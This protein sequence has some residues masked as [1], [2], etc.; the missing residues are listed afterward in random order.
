MSNPGATPPD[1]AR[2]DPDTPAVLL[3]RHEGWAEIVF[4]RPQRK[5]AIHG[6]FAQAFLKALTDAEEDDSLRVLLLRGE[7]G[8]FCSGLDLQE[9]NA[10]PKPAW[11]ADFGTIWRKAHVALASTRKIVLVALERLMGMLLVA[12]SVQMLMDGIQAYLNSP[13]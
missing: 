4:N 7:G 5:N 12:I 8:T 13:A 1:L 9:F 6:P 11:V 3:R 10:D 2:S